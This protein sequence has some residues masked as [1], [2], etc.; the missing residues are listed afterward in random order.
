[1]Y[2][3]S[4]VYR[5]ACLPANQMIK[6]YYNYV[7]TENVHI[8]KPGARSVRPCKNLDLNELTVPNFVPAFLIRSSLF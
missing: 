4:F 7:S 2:V 1:M 5:F 3:C 8:K 6:G